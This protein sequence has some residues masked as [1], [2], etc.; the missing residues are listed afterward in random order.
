MPFTFNWKKKV[1]KVE[2]GFLLGDSGNILSVKEADDLVILVSKAA[3]G[4]K[5]NS[6]TAQISCCVFH[7]GGHLIWDIRKWWNHSQDVK[8]AFITQIYALFLLLLLQLLQLPLLASTAT[9][10]S[11]C[12]WVTWRVF[13]SCYFV[14]LALSLPVTMCNVGDVGTQ[15][16]CF[17]HCLL[18]VKSSC[19]IC[20]T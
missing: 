19:P 13:S 10:L 11:L 14:F 20:I 17:A 2:H 7:A 8:Y 3:V 6:E 15:W 9:K 5:V 4:W 1:L 18:L 16:T 12:C